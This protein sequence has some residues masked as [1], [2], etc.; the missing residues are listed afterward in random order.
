MKK[1][2]AALS[3]AAAFAAGS[4]VTA[5]IT[6]QMQD[7]HDLDSVRKHVQEAIH[8]LDRARAANHFDA[9]GHGTRAEQFLRQAERELTDAVA[10]AQ[11]QDQ[12][13]EFTQP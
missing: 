5:Q 13:Q 6:A 9:S 10:S 8:E 2:L 11:E 1:L 4:L 12:E 3:L 7:W